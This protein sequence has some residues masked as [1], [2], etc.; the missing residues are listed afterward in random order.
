M[1]K[2][3]QI[4]Y[5]YWNE[6]RGTRMA[7]RRFEIEPSGMAGILAE[8]FILERASSHRAPFRLAGTR[9]CESFGR[10]LRGVDFLDLWGDADRAELEHDLATAADRGAVIV[11]IFEAKA[12]AGARVRFEALLLPLF[13]TRQQ[14]TRF[15]GAITAIDPPHWLGQEKLNV[16]AVIERQTIW[17]DGRPHTLVERLDRQSP[18]LPAA[19]AA[20]LVR[21][22]RRQFRVYDGGRLDGDSSKR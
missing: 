11:V 16:G 22:E 21:A 3:N 13:H 18:F 10:E 1:Q 6:L 2:T 8:T 12:A 20:R 7:P 17:P 19:Q 4:L 9:I 14:V 5:A 15:L